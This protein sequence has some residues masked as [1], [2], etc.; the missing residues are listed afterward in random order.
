MGTLFHVFVGA[1]LLH[2][3]WPSIP[4][5]FPHYGLPTT[6]TYW[7]CVSIQWVGVILFPPVIDSIEIGVRKGIEASRG[8][9]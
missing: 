5:I 2:W 8:A 1:L 3:A 4:E 6:L 9:K 7:Q